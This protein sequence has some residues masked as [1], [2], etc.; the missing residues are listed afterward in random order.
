MTDGAFTL[1]ATAIGHC[2]VAW[3]ARGI[4]AVGLPEG[5]EQ[6]TR[7][8][9]ARRF[10]AADGLAPPADVSLA[11]DRMTALLQGEPS[12]LS[13]IVLDLDG[14]PAFHRAVYD[15]ARTIPAGATLTYGEVAARLR[16]PG[17]AREVGQALGRNPFPLI[18]PCHR[19][20]AASGRLG[21]FS[22]YGGSGTKL[23]LLTIEGAR[24]F[25]PD[26]FDAPIGRAG[27]SPMGSASTPGSGSWRP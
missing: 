3:S 7:R 14:I 1:F 25:T 5:S 22:A 18:V 16:E 13:G 23:R 27:Q 11:I 17:L 10:A 24:G 8:R 21:G 6:A 4:V 20:V 12:D 2:A 9:M 26:L 15:I 19:V